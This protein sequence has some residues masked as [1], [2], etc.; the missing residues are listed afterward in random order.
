MLSLNSLSIA[1]ILISLS[2]LIS[3]LNKNDTQNLPAQSLTSQLINQNLKNLQQ[4]N[5]KVYQTSFGQ[6]NQQN[7]FI[8]NKPINKLNQ[9]NQ[10]SQLNQVA[11]TKEISC[12][13][14]Q[15]INFLKYSNRKLS[16]NFLNKLTEYTASKLLDQT[17][18][19]YSKIN[20]DRL[21]NNLNLSKPVTQ[22]CYDACRNDLE[23]LA[24]TV[25]LKQS[26]CYLVKEDYKS[27]NNRDHLLYDS[28]NSW[29]F[30]E[31]VC[32]E[33]GKF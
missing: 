21:R 18:S 7:Q 9:L 6:L 29:N 33:K 20:L 5:D 27:N 3:A 24:F 28:T 8:L 15:T 25:N 22:L 16:L 4:S 10:L 13:Q 19:L 2:N 32:F 14:N 31:K 23:C 30:Y 11:Q 17:P 12:N 1:L 26:T